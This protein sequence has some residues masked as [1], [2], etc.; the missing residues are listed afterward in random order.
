MSSK[1]HIARGL[2][3]L[4]P[5]PSASILITCKY[6]HHAMRQFIFVGSWLSDPAKIFPDTEFTYNAFYLIRK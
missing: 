4:G 6:F 3:W 5:A 1:S 2:G